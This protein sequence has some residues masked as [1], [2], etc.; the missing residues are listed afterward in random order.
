MHDDCRNEGIECD[1]CFT[2]GPGGQYIKMQAKKQKGLAR[3][4]QKADKRAGSSFEYRNHELNKSMLADTITS[5]TVNSGATVLEKGDEQIRG[6]INIME[7]DKTKTVEQA[8]GKKTF[9]IQKK[10]L[11]KLLKESDAEGMEF[12]YLKFSFHE[13]DKD[14]YVIIELDQI[15]S[16]VKTMVSD[17]RRAKD[18]DYRIQLEQKKNEALRTE[19]AA[20]RAKLAYLKKKEEY[21]LFLNESEDTV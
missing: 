2:D 14:I 21:D 15:Q 9:T 19:N 18:C 5:M 20:L 13:Y 7:E 4:Q 6:L 16:M 10:W 1:L 11:D 3:R 8:P 12:H 17:R